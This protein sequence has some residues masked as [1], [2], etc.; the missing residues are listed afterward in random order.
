[1]QDFLCPFSQT[2]RSE[3]FGCA[4]GVAVTRRDGPDVCC[5]SRPAQERC[6][7][8]FQRMKQ[9]ALPAFG[10]EDDPQRMPHSVLVKI[11]FGGLLGL[12]QNLGGPSPQSDRV[13]NIHAL[14]DHAVTSYG[15]LTDVPVADLIADITSY[16]VKRRR[17]R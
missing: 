1:M 14:V 8:L 12:Q 11:Q 15:S 3:A 7:A 17:G 9:R 13:E 2:L 10:V 16:K 4:H 5:N 6:S